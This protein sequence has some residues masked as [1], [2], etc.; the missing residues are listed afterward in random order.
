MR[1]LAS[2][3]AETMDNRKMYNLELDGRTL[4]TFG[5]AGTIPQELGPVTFG[6]YPQQN[7]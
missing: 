3:D 4:G 6:L 7:R 2:N 5:R 1:R